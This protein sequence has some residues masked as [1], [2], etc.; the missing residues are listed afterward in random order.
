MASAS[1]F[2]VSIRLH[3]DEDTAYLQQRLAL[4]HPDGGIQGPRCAKEN[5][6]RIPPALELL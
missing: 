2:Q 6:Q 4:K 5:E 3:S 1:R